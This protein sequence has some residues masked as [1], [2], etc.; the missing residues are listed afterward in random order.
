[1]T[2]TKPNTPRGKMNNA[3]NPNDLD[4]LDAE[5]RKQVERRMRLLGPSYRLFYSNPVEI[6]KAKG[7]LLW[8]KN[9]NEYLDAYN[10][11]VSIGHGHPRVVA[12]VAEQMEKLC[13][14]TRYVSDNILNFAEKLLATFGGR[15]GETG[16]AM[17]TCTGSE[18]ND[19]AIRIAKHHT[20]RNGIIV[21][22]EAYH[23]NSDMTASFS[24]SLGD[25]SPLG[26]WVRRIAAPDAYRMPPEQIGRILAEQVREQVKD[27]ERHGD[28]LAAF[29]VD[30]LFTSDGIYPWAQDVLA[31][32]AEAVKEAGGLFI[33]D[34]VQCG[35]GRCGDVMWGY[36]R[37]GI[38][39][40]I[41]TMG[42]PM[43]NGYPVAGIAVAPEV[44]ADFGRDMRYFNTFGGNTV[45]IAAAQ[46]TF[47]VI[48]EEQLM[49][50]CA[51]VGGILLE[52]LQKM[53]TRYPQIGDVR[54]VGL[55]LGVEIIS[56][57]A[58]KT[59][60]QKTAARL[61]NALRERRVLI[62]ATGFHGNVLKIRPPLVFSA[63][64]AARLL[65][66]IDAVFASL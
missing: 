19:L 9:G 43:G 66:D 31:P 27:L 51:R 30:S 10:N 11:V 22:S 47:D 1:M 48:V 39:P 60:D 26:T 29:V 59:P 40:D 42:K 44:V 18:A 55:Y 17:F 65:A 58:N 41:V 15:I 14:H 6:S 32:V 53:A 24:P 28:G 21:T 54:G 46:A 8:D 57:A 7:V 23:G 20:G 35:F 64:N 63:D 5:T 45:A 49:E 13:T 37:H 33:A 4:H 34:E 25:H 52:G 2:T 36:Q 61:V 50:N 16:H 38:D 62:S 12:A 56:D 3:F